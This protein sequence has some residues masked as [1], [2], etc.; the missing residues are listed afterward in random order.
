MS[1]NIDNTYDLDV[2]DQ[3]STAVDLTKK[4]SEQTNGSSIMS[5]QSDDIWWSLDDKNKQ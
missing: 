4:I 3:R 1:L 5:E 2:Y